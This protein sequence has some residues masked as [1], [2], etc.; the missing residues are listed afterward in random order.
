MGRVS[1]PENIRWFVPVWLWIA[2]AGW[3]ELRHFSPTI[4]FVTFFFVFF[5][6]AIPF[7][8]R[9]VGL[10]RWWLFGWVIPVIAM[11]VALQCLRSAFH[12]A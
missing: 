11:A 3:I 8:C 12:F 2:L 1:A 5:A 10:I 7:F 4:L 9:R 6:S